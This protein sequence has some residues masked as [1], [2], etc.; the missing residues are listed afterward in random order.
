MTDV[1]R[2]LD[3]IQQWMQTAL[4]APGGAAH[5][6]E[7][8][9]ASGRMSAE[10]RLRVYR[11]GYRLRLLGCMRG[12]YPAMAQLLGREL[13]DGFAME[14]LDAHP[15]R[16]PT[17]DDLGAGFPDHLARTRPDAG[18]DDTPPE[19]WVDLLIDLAR[20]ERDFAAAFDAPDA[21]TSTGADTDTRF[22]EAR[23]PVHRY[24]AAVRRGEEPEPPEAEPV[25]LSLTRRDGT[26]VVHDL[27]AP[28][29][30]QAG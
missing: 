6:A 28:R 13:F 1:P 8:I 23:F 20:F 3:A 29:P 4:L 19:A 9:T 14:Y 11:R 12:Q 5:V 21:D 17:L 7:V 25:R 30:P 15:S 27:T 26:V 24:A 18:A 22:F 2:S 16:S 10:E